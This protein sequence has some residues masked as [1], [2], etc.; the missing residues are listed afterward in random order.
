MELVGNILDISKIESGKLEVSEAS[1]NLVSEVR[2]MATV[3]ETR[4][5]EKDIKFF[6]RY[7]DNIPHRLIG[8][9]RMVKEVIANLLSNAFKYTEKGCVTLY[10][11]AENTEDVSNLTIEVRDTGSGISEEDL[12]KLPQKID[13]D[14]VE[15]EAVI[16]NDV[17]FEEFNGKRVLVVDDNKLNRKVFRVMLRGSEALVE[18]KKR[19]DFD[20]PVVILSADAVEDAKER[21][22]GEGFDAYMSKHYT[23]EA[24]HGMMKR[25]LA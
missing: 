16:M 3:T 20:M 5:G 23:K 24:L 4:I 11:D 1:Y 21:Y 6:S 18:L 25:I 8:D 17:T 9:K 12:P 2:A 13:K 7:A 14:Y 15:P 19:E 10:V 22:L